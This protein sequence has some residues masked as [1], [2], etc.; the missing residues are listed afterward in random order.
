MKKH[1]FPAFLIAIFV[2]LPALVFAGKKDAELFDTIKASKQL[3]GRYYNAGDAASLARMY[4]EDAT[5]IAPNFPPDK[6]REAIQAGLQGELDLGDGTI[7]LKTL[8]VHRIN[9][10]TAW[11]IGYYD[12]KIVLAEGDPIVDEGHYVIIWKHVDDEWLLHLDTWNTSL[13]LE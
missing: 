10:V 1:L 11:E 4:T 9:K 8:E 6:G 2:L 3:W 12:L 5:V 13:P 7:E